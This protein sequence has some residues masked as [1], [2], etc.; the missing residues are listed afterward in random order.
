MGQKI[1]SVV[2]VK[3]EEMTGACIYLCGKASDNE[4]VVFLLPT[5]AFAFHICIDDFSQGT[6]I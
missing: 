4:G 3:E 5:T 1:R 6:W 2:F